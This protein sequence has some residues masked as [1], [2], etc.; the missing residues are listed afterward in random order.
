IFKGIDRI[1]INI[2]EAK[3]RDFQIDKLEYHVNTPEAI[4]P[5]AG[6]EVILVVAPAGKLDESKIKAFRIKSGNGV[7]LNSGVR[8]FIPY[9]FKKNINCLVI[10]KDVTGED[11]LTFDQLAES[12][13]I[14]I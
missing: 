14:L 10:F 11:D 13:Q 9:P 4:I 2:L 8:H 3:K 6:D 1:S 12:Y 7:F 5:L